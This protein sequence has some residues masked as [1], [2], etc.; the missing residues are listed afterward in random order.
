[1]SKF[2]PPDIFPNK[3]I[4]QLEVI[5]AGSFV[6]DATT[7][8]GDID[9]GGRACVEAVDAHSPYE[10]V[11]QVPHAPGSFALPQ[12][13]LVK[14]I[15]GMYRIL[16]LI[17]EQGSGGLVDK[18][19]IDQESFRHFANDMSPGAYTSLTKVD[20]KA[21]DKVIVHPIGVYGD[22]NEII[23]LLHS[24]SIIDDPTA[25]ALRG[26][27]DDP[28]GPQLRSGLYLARKMTAPASPEHIFAIYW[29][30]DT[31]WRD[32]AATSV[33]RNRVTFMRQVL[34]CLHCQPPTNIVRR[35]LTKLADQIIC[36]LSPDQ[37]RSI[38]WKDDIEEST[39]T[40]LDDD[41]LD[42]LFTFEVAKTKEQEENVT[43]RP[44][45]SISSPDIA[46]DSTV[47]SS[48]ALPELPAHLKLRLL[49][50]ETS[51]AFL[52][53]AYIPSSSQTTDVHQSF[54]LSQLQNFLMS[55]LVE[56]PIAMEDDALLLFVQ[57]GL[58]A[59]Y[60]KSCEGWKT[61]RA[62]ITQECKELEQRELEDLK[63][64][65][66]KGEPIVHSSILRALIDRSMHFFP[67]FERSAIIPGNEN[68]DF[69]SEASISHLF[70]LYPRFEEEVR[71]ALEAAKWKTIPLKKF[72]DMKK[73]FI[74]AELFLDKKLDLEDEKREDWVKKALDKGYTPPK[75]SK[76]FIDNA[77]GMVGVTVSRDV[78]V[79]QIMF[80]QADEAFKATSDFDFLSRLCADAGRHHPLLEPTAA[81]VQDTAHLYIREQIRKHLKHLYEKA[82][83]LQESVCQIQIQRLGSSRRAERQR[84]S[85]QILATDMQSEASPDTRTIK[86]DNV[87]IDKTIL[88]YTMQR[89]TIVGKTITQT[90]PVLEYQ[91]HV[92]GLSADHRHNLQ[93]DP[94]FIPSPQVEKRL[95]YSFRLP[96]EYQILHAQLLENRILVIVDDRREG[97]SVYLEALDTIGAAVH[98]GR[99]RRRLRHDKIGKD[100]LVAFDETKRMLSLC[101][102]TKFQL[103]IFVFD[104]KYTS[105]QA[106]GNSLNLAPWYNADISI[107][108][109]CFVSCTEEILLID[110]SG[111][112]R[113]FSLVTQ[114]FRPASLSL[115]HI[116]TAAFAS[117][118]GAC[119][120]LLYPTESPVLRAYHWATFGST[121]GIPLDI[122]LLNGRDMVL[123]SMA[124]RN[125]VHLLELDPVSNCC[126][127]I[128]L[129]IT[130]KATEF[131][132]K[133]KGSRNHSSSRT[134]GSVC[135]C[136]IDSHAEVWTR[137]PVVPAVQRQTITSANRCRKS[138]IFVTETSRHRYETYFA[139][140]I[141]SFEQRS[142][143][144]T[145]DELK[146]IAIEAI[147]FRDLLL[148]LSKE[149]WNPSQ[150]R[151]GE[152]LVDLLCLI[153][154]HI[155]ITRENRFIPLKDGVTSAALEK[156]LL[157]AEVGRIVDS[158]SMGWYESIF[159]SYMTDKPVKVVS[160]M[161]E[162]SVGKSFSLNHL[163]DTS[164]AGSAMRTTE[165]VWMSVTPTH[166]TMVVALDFEGV[167]SIERSAQEDTLLVLFNTAISNLVLF[168]NNFALSRDITGLFQSF[169][170]SSTVLDPSANPSLFRS[171]LAIIIKDVVDS[172]KSEIVREFSLKFQKIVQE[173]QDAN[174]ISRL[175]AGRLNIIP[176]PVIESKQFYTLFPALKR[177]LDRQE[178]THHTAGEFLHTL[179]TLMAKIKANDWGA[180]SQTLAAHRAHR[181]HNMLP[182]ALI[183][184]FSEVDP[185]YEPLKNL[186]TDATIEKA[187]TFSRFVYIGTADQR[188]SALA[189]LCN[190]WGNYGSRFHS[191]E[192]DWIEQLSF[193]L[194]HLVDMRI[195]HVQEW[196]SSNLSRFK[197]EN[198]SIDELRRAVETAITSHRCPHECEFQD[199][200][201]SEEVK[202]CGYSAGH[203][204]QHICVVDSHLCGEACM[205][206]DKQ[207][208]LGECTEVAGHPGDVHIC[209]ARVHACGEPCA[210][211]VRLNG[212]SFTCSGTCNKPRFA[213]PLEMSLH[214]TNSRKVT[215]FMAT[216]P[217]TTEC[218]PSNVNFANVY[219]Q[220]PTICMA[221]N[222]TSSTYAANLILVLPCVKRRVFA[223]L[224][225]RL[226]RSK[227]HSQA[228]M[229][230]FNIRS[231]HKWR[232]GFGVL[233]L[234]REAYRVMQVDIYIARRRHRSIFVK[235]AARAVDTFALFHAGIRSKSTRQAM[236]LCR[237]HVGQLMVRTVQFWSLMDESSL[238]TMTAR[239]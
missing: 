238:L 72:Q 218:V 228:D 19:V 22:K 98:H 75:A 186:D 206:S 37:S 57:H 194:Y 214:V 177:Q 101:A 185:D 147:S 66:T 13:D 151:A 197:T 59:R 127:S 12:M 120:L 92:L 168:R 39:I 118:D 51:Q 172:D 111:Q 63:A 205:L 176:W 230:L 128:A 8:C 155:A 117:P 160:S 152:W 125:S 95:S 74:T 182:N 80:V 10:A 38:I 166:D 85:R 30:E 180:L 99:P 178:I 36:L 42:R 68:E 53:V 100:I 134:A 153:P 50:G 217:V 82:K 223:R 221:L 54:T 9:L 32:D 140:L 55:G 26:S 188:D 122:S 173:E 5:A 20:F 78:P 112:A 69:S 25:G 144:P 150:I 24:M 48:M 40:E 203:P 123:T 201:S 16:D 114:Q 212:T 139:E 190:S 89:V 234:S 179:K 215:K 199:E 184:G 209:A 142:R 226:S 237:R 17:S 165:G 94:S 43:I 83:H 15:D 136:L 189:L 154:I 174:F 121:S 45:F 96:V 213:Q 14:T 110:T 6:G 138:I 116:P 222:P 34:F 81:T 235:H 208:C 52:K 4:S 33:R 126:Q 162:Q 115:P 58:Q 231:I 149:S 137:F 156:T 224:K 108:R 31:T 135:N 148:W 106:W 210:L 70:E 11:P 158:L 73:R 161:G 191:T 229:K 47:S 236:A 46:V 3:G 91:I 198:A 44:G 109:S 61:R 131:M 200:H 216:I 133:E 233:S 65:L 107:C 171:T 79:E 119:L 219:V 103:Y 167:H 227:R 35:Y 207:G 104:E 97:L 64:E 62:T 28:S 159:Q 164:F 130:K 170:S 204:G 232:N 76:S 220:I 113:I 88:G 195:E 86:L 27:R 21:L 143:K 181:L 141:R 18:V 60:P 77:L 169:Q 196:I 132:F 145:G 71:R 1:M 157:G 87:Q 187:D 23:S 105:L 84:V 202:V 193:H 225:L 163:V 49:A 102:S 2:A 67:M 211:A 175:H 192:S 129:D 183:F 7:K 239:Q 90:E 29:P 56:L 93:L 146:N 41:Q 124:N